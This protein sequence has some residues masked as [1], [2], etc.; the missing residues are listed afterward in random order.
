M[1]ELKPVNSY[2]Q[3]GQILLV[4]STFMAQEGHSFVFIQKQYQIL[5]GGKSNAF[6]S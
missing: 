2:S 1:P 3:M 4:A 5:R 6:D